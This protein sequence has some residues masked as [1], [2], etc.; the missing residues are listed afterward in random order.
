LFSDSHYDKAFPIMDRLLQE[1]PNTPFLHYAYGDALAATSMYDEAQVQLQEET[2]LN[3]GSVLPYLR[4]ASIALLQHDFDGA[5]ENSKK[6]T[7]MAPDSAEA[8]YLLGRSLL[9][10]GE[11][12]GAIREL[13]I[14][15]QY[16]PDSPKVHFNLARAYT[17]ANRPAFA[18]KERAEFERLN[19]LLPGQKKSYGDRAARGSIDETGVRP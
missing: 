3:P 9:E 1:Y 11:V 19:A 2:R 8:H 12:A 18:E 13:E 16:S 7:A 10:A 5:L 4:L 6:A 15:R 14:A 17:K